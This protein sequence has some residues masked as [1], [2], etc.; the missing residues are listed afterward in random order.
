MRQASL[1]VKVQ[2]LE[3]LLGTSDLTDKETSFVESLVRQGATKDTTRL[4]DPQVEWLDD[5]WSKHF[6]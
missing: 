3:G 1:H 4:S 5:L 2:Q 6:A